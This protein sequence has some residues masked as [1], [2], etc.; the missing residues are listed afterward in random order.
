MLYH[1][2]AALAVVPELGGHVGPRSTLYSLTAEEEAVCI[3]LRWPLACARERRLAFRMA[4]GRSPRRLPRA[5]PDTGRQR[6]G[7]PALPPGSVPTVT[8]A[9]SVRMRL[10]FVCTLPKKCR[11]IYTHS[12]S[13][14][15][16][17]PSFCSPPSLLFIFRKSSHFAINTASA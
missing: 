5:S 9:G 10:P 12:N 8:P 4:A 11:Y 6:R 7:V 1:L 3:S 14:L 2:F 17:F 13:T 16:S 15:I